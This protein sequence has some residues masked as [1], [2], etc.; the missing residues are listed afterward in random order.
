MNSGRFWVP[1][2]AS[3]HG[4][5]G[6]AKSGL[7]TWL[8]RLGGGSP[9]LQRRPGKGPIACITLVHM[10]HPIFMKG[11]DIR[12]RAP[13]TPPALFARRRHCASDV[14]NTIDARSALECFA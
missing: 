3:F 13:S 7:C 14:R 10:T 1:S 2:M 12:L 11:M 8:A 5:S 6:R 4:A 9:T